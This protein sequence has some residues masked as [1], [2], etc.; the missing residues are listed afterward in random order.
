MDYLIK[1]IT[2]VNEHGI[3][4]NQDILIRD[5]VMKKIGTDLKR[6]SE[7]VIDGEGLAAFPGFC[8]LHSHLRDPGLLYKED[9]ESGTRSA[10]AGGYTTVCCMPNTKPTIDSADVVSY[11]IQKDK[12]K[13]FAEVLPVAAITKGMQGE[14][15][16]D[17]DALRA[18]GAVAF[19]DDGLPVAKDCMI[20]KAMEKA[21]EMSALLMLHEEDLAMRGDGVVN[22]GENARKAGLR[23]IS[24]AVEEAMTERDIRYAEQIGAHIHICHVSTMGSVEVI[25]NAKKR[26]V[27]VTCETAPHY[28]SATDALILDRNPN[29]KVNPPLRSEKD[30]QAVIVGIL[31]GTIDAIATDHAPH[32]MEE[33]KK[34][35]ES[36][37][38][39]LIGFETAF[40]LA[41]TNLLEPGIIK[42]EDIARLMSKTPRQLLGIDGG[43][44]CEGA[45]ADLAICDIRE[46]YVYEEKDV[47]SKAKN[48]P[49]LGKTLKG[50][51]QYTFRKG[52]LVYD[53]Q[54]D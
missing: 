37:P 17:F 30:R 21:K 4:E 34:P 23:G 27:C 54:A 53:R 47:V 11:I 42:I 16:T 31:D 43:V 22:E 51:V 3:S 2:I 8:D 40:S 20:R 33:K 39:G 15:L 38:F 52:K 10:A 28:F 12:E 44:V 14:E 1:N 35:I 36:A 25:R 26:G 46:S 29:A 5:G 48:S 13:G 41:V 9:I 6:E 49:F 45:S 18:A 7:R 24:A 50:R 32:S 19:S